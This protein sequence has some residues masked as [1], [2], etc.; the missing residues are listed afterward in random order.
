MKLDFCAP[1]RPGLIS[2]LLF[3]LGLT[4][5]GWSLSIWLAADELHRAAEARLAD[6]RRS[7]PA[8]ARVA[9]PTDRATLANLRHD[10]AARDQLALPW[11]GLFD[12]LHGLRPSEIALLSLDADGRRADFTLTALA[13]DQS[14]L[15]EWFDTLRQAPAL[16][17]VSLTRHELRE[18]DGLQVVYFNLRGKWGRP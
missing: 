9:S 8:A 4:A 10:A 12:S 5:A 2:W 3:A 18:V 7:A 13:I 16:D 6:L 11:T 14:A 17:E 15:L 1:S